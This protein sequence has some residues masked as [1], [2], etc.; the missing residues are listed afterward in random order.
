MA[1]LAAVLIHL[2]RGPS[3]GILGICWGGAQPAADA[4]FADSTPTGA[5]DKVYTVLG[6]ISFFSNGAGQA[7][8]MLLF[9]LLGNT[10]DLKNLTII[11]VTGLIMQVPVALSQ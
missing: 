2:A 4:I 10:W 9:Y 1:T 3:Y 8:T 6:S 11:M 5:R 7:V